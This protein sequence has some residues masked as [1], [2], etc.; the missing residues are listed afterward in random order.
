MH[1]GNLSFFLGDSL[2]FQLTP[3][4]D[5][6]PMLWA[7]GSQGEIIARRFAP[8]PPLPEMLEPWQDAASRAEDFWGR[9]AGD[10]RLSGEFAKIAR[11][12]GAVVRQLRRHMD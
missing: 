2:P 11:D 8:A 6:V 12:A 5:I 10:Q 3:A 9:V 1:F 7:P 4:Y